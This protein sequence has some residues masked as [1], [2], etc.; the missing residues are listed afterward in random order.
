MEKNKA[1]YET[2]DSGNSPT[3]PDK[4]NY[5]SNDSAG[6]LGE[7]PAEHGEVPEVPQKSK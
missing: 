3:I 6:S 5:A 7:S 2:F 1:D 4:D